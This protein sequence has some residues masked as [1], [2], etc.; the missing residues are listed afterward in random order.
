MSK[1]IN[2]E[3]TQLVII[4]LVTTK[5]KKSLPVPSCSALLETPSATVGENGRRKMKV[6]NNFKAMAI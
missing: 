2:K 3:T 5:P 1:M 6:M 4:E